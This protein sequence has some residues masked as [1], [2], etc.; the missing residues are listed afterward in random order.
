MLLE[1]RIMPSRLLRLWQYRPTQSY[2]I[3]MST[4]KP[5]HPHIQFP[6]PSMVRTAY[7]VTVFHQPARYVSLVHHSAPVFTTRHNTTHLL[8]ACL[9]AKDEPSL[10][11][12]YSISLPKVR[13]HECLTQT[14]FRKRTEIRSKDARWWREVQRVEGWNELLCS[15]EVKLMAGGG[16]WIFGLGMVEYGM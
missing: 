12:D 13:F 5:T 8:L 9:L 14:R 1:F 7:L 15:R 11:H 16:L 4:L 2:P 3:L 10:W 6:P